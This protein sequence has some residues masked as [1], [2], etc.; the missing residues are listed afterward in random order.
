M[1]KGKETTT[2]EVREREL[3]RFGDL[4]ALGICADRQTM[5]QMDDRRRIYRFCNRSSYPETAS[6]GAQQKVGPG[7]TVG[8]AV[9]RPSQTTWPRAALPRPRRDRCP[10]QARGLGRYQRSG[11]PRIDQ[12]GG[13][14]GPTNSAIPFR[15]SMSFATR[16]AAPEPRPSPPELPGLPRY[17]EPL[18]HPRAPSLS[19]TAS[20]WAC[21]P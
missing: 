18:R 10:S 14:I 9:P 17:Y 15:I 6:P 12:L 8:P 21:H 7:S 2:A 3:R 20:S 4:Q 16:R 5:R 13:E 19:L 11:D 1:S